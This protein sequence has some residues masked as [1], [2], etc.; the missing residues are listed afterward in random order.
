MKKYIL[1][2][3]YC[4]IVFS[5]KT[6]NAQKLT[7]DIKL[8]QVGFYTNAP[9]QAFLT[10]GST[11]KYFYITSTNLRDTFYTGTLG[12]IHKSA[13]STTVAQLADFSAFQKK[14]KLCNQHQ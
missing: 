1:L 11:E 3:C 13:Y 14:R 10:G 8:N 6:V 12:T 7:E 2:L 5:Y 9:K 4:F